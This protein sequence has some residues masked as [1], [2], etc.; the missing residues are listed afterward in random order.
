MQ[1]SNQ[2]ERDEWQPIE[3]C[4]LDTPILIW[5]KV[6]KQCVMAISHLRHRG[7]NYF[8]VEYSYGFNED[9]EIFASDVSNWR[10]P[11]EGPT[12]N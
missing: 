5:D 9:G 10:L 12:V 2:R 11:P 4:P 8:M 6:R 1:M 3:T 7:G